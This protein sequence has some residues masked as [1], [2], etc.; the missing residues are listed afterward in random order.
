MSI[1]SMLALANQNN[2]VL[3]VQ[4]GVSRTV[5]LMVTALGSSPTKLTIYQLTALQR[6]P[7]SIVVDSSGTGFKTV[8]KVTVPSVA[9]RKMIE[10]QAVMRANAIQIV[11][12]GIYYKV[13]QVVT[14][15]DVSLQIDS[16]DQNGRVQSLSI[17]NAPAVTAIDQILFKP[18][19]GTGRDLAVRFT[20]RLDAITVKTPGY[21]SA[22]TIEINGDGTGAQ[23]H[24]VLSYALQ[25]QHELL[26][27]TL[28][29]N[30]FTLLKDLPLSGDDVLLV[31]P[32]QD[33][34]VRIIEKH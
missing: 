23:A 11:S 19:G 15:N 1:T 21:V 30:E 31:K 22:E 27:A 13:G 7:S 29:V 12:A 34:A 26:T 9:D 32:T 20:Y 2:E 33:A 18:T 5:D 14:A 25:P 16:V 24:L 3:R 6:S 10:L 8:P 4:P 17:A 28:G